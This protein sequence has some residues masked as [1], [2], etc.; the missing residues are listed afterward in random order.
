[1]RD[2]AEPPRPPVD[3]PG[4]VASALRDLSVHDLRESIIYAQ[5]LLQYRQA[6]TSQVEPGPDEEFV[7]LTEH[8]G[9]VEVVKRQPCV[10]GCD[11]CPHGP[12]VYHVTREPRPDGSSTY[13]WVLIGRRN[14][15]TA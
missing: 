6:P 2:S 12:F 14:G 13:H 8:P 10:D 7:E 4:P 9:Y 5:E 11:D 15:S 1:M 3:L